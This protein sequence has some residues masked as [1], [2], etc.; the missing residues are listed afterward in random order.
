MN[1]DT[2]IGEELNVPILSCSP[3]SFEL[4]VSNTV[5][6]DGGKVF[7]CKIKNVLKE[8]ILFDSTLTIVERSKIIAPISIICTTYFLGTGVVLV[9]GANLKTFN[10]IIKII[11]VR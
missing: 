3:S 11:V 9:N 1:F 10:P 7:L 6:L 2:Q 8:E 5:A 4:E